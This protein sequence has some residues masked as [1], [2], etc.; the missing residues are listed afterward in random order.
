MKGS[1]MEIVNRLPLEW[2][3]AKT[4][5]TRRGKRSLR[6]GTPGEDF[7]AIWKEHKLALK[8]LGVSVRKE[9]GKFQVCH[10]H[11]DIP[12]GQE[13]LRAPALR[14]ARVVAPAL[15]RAAEEQRQ[16]RLVAALPVPAG[17]A[18]LPYQVEGIHWLASRRSGILADE[19]GLGKTVQL[20]GLVNCKLPSR[21]LIICPAHLKSNWEAEAEKWLVEKRMS[22]TISGRMGSKASRIA[23]GRLKAAIVQPEGTVV[24]V[25]YEILES[26]LPLLV[27][28]SQGALV[29]ADEAHYIKNREAKR[30]GATREVC[31]GADRV[32]MI[33][34]TPVLNRPEE[35]FPPATIIGATHRSWTDFTNAFCDA[36]TDQYGVRQTHGAS[37][38][39]LLRKEIGPFILR[40]LKSDV[41][42]QLPEKVRQVITIEPDKAGAKAIQEEWNLINQTPSSRAGGGMIDWEEMRKGAA[43]PKTLSAFA[44]FRQA[45]GLAKVDWALK[46][47]INLLESDLAPN[48]KLIVFAHHVDVGKKLRTGLAKYGA[49][50]FTGYTPPL[51]RDA[52]VKAFQNPSHPCRI[53]IGSLGAMGTGVTL[54]EAK[55]VVFVE[56]DWSPSVNAQCEDR[57]HRIGQLDSV[58]VQYLVLRGSLD[59]RAVRACIRKQGIVN[60]LMDE[61]GKK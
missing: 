36:Y 29:A 39:E 33:T 16:A 25:N 57:A 56:A 53:I 51:E 44:K 11:E 20:L 42:P 50:L 1:T 43:G 59:E 13:Q 35:I 10:W 40:R 17:L 48:K 30:T 55:A 15:V 22:V 32:V 7:W 34:G 38:L 24:I 6:L 8:E 28:Y 41:L 52:T 45:S 9:G 58:L 3:E 54:T 23:E 26:W 19:M 31:L 60:T 37:N 14:P 2:G 27:Q 47:I 18:Y 4:V 12:A 46:H 5:N 49:K 21:V 61:G